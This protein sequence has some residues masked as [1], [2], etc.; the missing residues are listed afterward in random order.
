[1]ISDMN[2]DSTDGRS[3]ASQVVAR[4]EI[5]DWAAKLVAGLRKPWKRAIVALLWLSLGVAGLAVAKPFMAGLQSEADPVPGTPSGDAQDV[6]SKYFPAEPLTGA[7]LLKSSD[8]RPLL[9]FVNR[10]TCSIQDSMTSLPGNVMQV[11]INCTNASALGGGCIPS[12]ELNDFAMRS[13]TAILAVANVSGIQRSF[14][15]AQLKQELN[16]LPQIDGCPEAHIGSNNT[17]EWLDWGSNLRSQLNSRLPDYNNTALSFSSLP[18]QTLNTTI[19]ASRFKPGLPSVQVNLKIPAGQFWYLLK[20]QLLADDDRT[21][22]VAVQTSRKDGQLVLPMSDD[23]KAVGAV[24]TDLASSA[25]DSLTCKESAMSSMFVSIQGGID[26]TMK[27]S[28]KTLPIALLILAAMAQNI[29]LVVVTVIN[30]LA[31]ITSAIL[32]MY[33]ITKVMSTATMAP[34]MMVAIA[35]AMSI[36]YSLFLLTRFQR[37]IRQGRSV[38]DAVAITLRTSGRIVMISGATLLLCFLMMLCLPVAIIYSMGVSASITVLMAVLAALTLTPAVLLQCPAFLTSNKR[39]GLSLEGCCCRRDARALAPAE[40]VRIGLESGSRELLS[41][42]AAE[43]CEVSYDKGWGK[44]GSFIQRFAWIVAFALVATA[45]PIFA[46]TIPKMNHSVGLLP[47]M[48]SD[49]S[50]THTLEELQDSF[51]AGSVFPTTLLVVPT[52]GS[53]ETDDA[54]SKWLKSTCEALQGIAQSVNTKDDGVPPFTVK[55]FSGVMI[56]DGSCLPA[57][58]G[59]AMGQWSHVG[60][61]YAAT[62]IRITYAIDPFSTEGQKWIIR[63]RKAI[64]TR[65]ARNLGSWYVTGAAPIQMDV[66]NA[67]FARLPF[68]IALM[69]GVVIIVM[70]VSFR[71][72]VAPLRAVFCLLWMLIVTFGI[73]I[74]V[75]Q[76]GMLD[77]LNWGSVGARPTGAMTWM[78]P[79]MSFS[80]LVGLGLDYDIFYSERVVEE[81]EHGYDEKEAAVR[82]LSETANIITA[83]GVIMV[84]AFVALLISTTPAL[85]EIAFLLIVGVIIDCFITTKVIIPCVMA[86]LGRFNFWPRQNP[87]RKDL[88]DGTSFSVRETSMAA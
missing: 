73:A 33:P 22:L 38:D 41:R 2:A 78:S 45:V 72:L 36:D 35:L 50:A 80:V 18:S 69:M 30:L 44:F 55:S 58:V 74:Y 10:S 9:N 54:L 7:F 79:C 40:D 85:N 67:T 62:Q 26:K 28:S 57:K 4:T 48:P 8:G 70:G 21:S 23:A 63:L 76:D 32:L 83:A 82:A 25:P 15:L 20:G 59:N 14:I 16:A 66:S 19:D 39:W 65:E 42:H 43:N 6:F 51:G 13:A 11:Q 88:T 12:A 87:A 60:G 75:F 47:M 56:L 86:L 71:S 81:W 53:T 68:M 77:F 31:C 52:K 29:R 37:E 3:A 84:V 24:L 61:K 34:A 64:D 27:L 17:L 1:M 5:D 49:A 46:T